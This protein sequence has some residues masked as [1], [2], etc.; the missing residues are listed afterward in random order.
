MPHSPGFRGRRSASKGEG[1]SRLDFPL[2]HDVGSSYQP[3]N[4]TNN[5][6]GLAFYHEIRWSLRLL[7]TSLL[8]SASALLH[9]CIVISFPY[10][11]SMYEK[12]KSKFQPISFCFPFNRRVIR[13]SC[14]LLQNCPPSHGFPLDYRI[15][16]HR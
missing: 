5:I 15:I 10:I 12:V 7:I 16:D 4:N 14:T 11:E 1:R 8:L 9:S 13:G 2:I 3:Q 6:K